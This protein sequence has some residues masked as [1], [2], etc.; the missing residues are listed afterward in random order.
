MGSELTPRGPVIG[1]GVDLVDIDRIQGVIERQPRFV[2]R[3]YTAD[4]A[5]Y[6][7]AR[8]V[9]WERYAA[10]FAAKEAVMKAMGVGLGAVDLT[11]I[12]VVKAD[13]GRPSVRLSG[14]AAELAAQL[15]IAGWLLSLSHAREVAQATAIAL[16]A[17]PAD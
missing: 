8:K 7:A 4:E 11:E 15:G 3:T 14:R 13:S 2:E 6:C 10:R 17:D 12:E 5:A 9:P 16:A 1:L